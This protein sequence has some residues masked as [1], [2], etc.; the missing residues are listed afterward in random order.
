M[1]KVFPSQQ[2]MIRQDEITTFI[3]SL[4]QQYNVSL[5]NNTVSILESSP[6]REKSTVELNRKEN[7]KYTNLG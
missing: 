1:V 7:E 3:Q 2:M 5:F 6:L 4:Q